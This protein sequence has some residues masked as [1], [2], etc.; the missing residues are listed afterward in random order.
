MEHDH[1]SAS[2]INTWL[3]CPRKYRLHYIDRLPWQQK[4]ASMILGIAVHEAVEAYYKAVSEGHHPSHQD[5]HDM[6]ATSIHEST[7][8]TP[9]DT[10]DMEALVSQGQTLLDLFLANVQP[11]HIQAIEEPFNVALLDSDTGQVWDTPLVG[12]FD[13]VEADSTGTPVIV[14]LKT[15]A[16]RPSDTD[17]HT[18]IQLL[19]YAY[20][21]RQ[22][23]LVKEADP[24]LLRLDILLKTKTPS[25]EQRYLTLTADSDKVFL[26]L[27]T[28]IAEA[29]KAG[30]FPENPGW[31][32]GTCPLAYACSFGT[33]LQ[34]P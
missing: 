3:M 26:G 30:V 10:E 14:D 33:Y 24:V 27:A 2:Q 16:R 12:R 21:A 23:G 22:I 1:L 19:T 18:N 11:Q 9:T 28:G 17:L 32:C 20:A 15:M 8:T 31:Q 29:V 34:P 5:L 25:F 7:E 13:L 4:P 6:L